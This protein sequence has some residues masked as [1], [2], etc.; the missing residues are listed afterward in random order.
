MLDV[1]FDAVGITATFEQ[2]LEMLANK[3]RLVGVGMSAQEVSLGSTM[4]FNLTRKQVR[5]HLGYDVADIGTLA[6]L[7][8]TGRLD[9]SR[10]ISGIVSL[11]DVAE[12]IRILHEREGSP[13]RILVQP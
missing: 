13:V 6:R 7:V 10:S 4:L 2:A 9:L 1:A 8:S 5:G 3:G 11:E 12:G